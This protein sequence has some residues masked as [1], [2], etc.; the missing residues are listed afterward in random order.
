MF[1]PDFP[2]LTVLLVIPAVGAVSAAMTPALART[3]IRSIALA[4][5]ALTFVLSL[6]LLV[7]FEVGVAGFQEAFGNRAAWIPEWGISYRLDV[8]GISL[9]LILLTTLFMPLVILAAWEQVERAKGFFIALLALETALIGVFTATDL[10][11]FYVFFEAMLV[12]MYALIGVWGGSNRRY[13]SV[14]FFLYTLVGGLLMLVAILYLYFQGGAQSFDYDVLAQVDLTRTEELWLFAAFFV[15]FAIKVPLFPVHTWLPDAHTEAPTVGSVVL[16]A[17]L[18]KIG[19]YGFLR[20]NLPFFPEATRT[21]APAIL[22]LAIIGI[23]YG[24]LVAAMQRDIKRLIAYSSV[25][26]LGY[27]VLG[28]FALTGI[29]ASASVVQMINHGITTGALFLLVGFLYDRT[30][31]RLIADYSGTLH[32]TPIF[33]GIFLLGRDELD[34]AAV[35]QRLRGRVPDPPGDL[36]VLPVGRDRGGVRRDRRRALPAVGLPAHVP[37]AAGRPGRGAGRPQHPRARRDHPAARAHGGDRVRAA[38]AVRPHQ[39]LGRAGGRRGC[40]TR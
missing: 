17:V 13:A 33:G 28:T 6:A 14:K 36:P 24:A 2:L 5:T 4:S 38:V 7:D 32:A 1:G 30:H 27:V 3:T 21:F 15:A 9:F 12:P 23:L 40:R 25:A 8:D 22:I 16:A 19:S 20:F 18:L 26:H 35:A 11:L 39:P 31:S 34:R 37:R 10:M 29:S